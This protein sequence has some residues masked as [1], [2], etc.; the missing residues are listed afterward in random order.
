[1]AIQLVAVNE[2]CSHCHN[3]VAEKDID[4]E[5]K[6]AHV[7]G[8]CY[9][10]ETKVKGTLAAEK[11][12]VDRIADGARRANEAANKAYIEELRKINAE[13]V[14]DVTGDEDKQSRVG[15]AN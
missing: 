13:A 4:V 12:L 10:K 9:I 7:C 14:S 3:Y 15:S 5:G 2:E 8:D 6:I 1:M 11:R